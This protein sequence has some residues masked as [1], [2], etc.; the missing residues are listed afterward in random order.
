MR[1]FFWIVVFLLAG[2]WVSGCVTPP[3]STEGFLEVA[4]DDL[5]CP[6]NVCSSEYLLTSNGWLLEKIQNSGDS[7]N[8]V[9]ISVTRVPQESVQ[10][11]W[12]RLPPLFSSSM[13]ANCSSCPVWNSFWLHNGKLTRVNIGK[14]FQDENRSGQLSDIFFELKQLSD[15]ASPSDDLFVQFVFQE[16]G[17]RFVDYHFFPDG[18]FVRS[19]FGFGNGEIL[20]ARVGNDPV[21]VAKVFDSVSDDF[22]SDPAA[23]DCPASLTHGSMIVSKGARESLD[24]FCV[25]SGAKRLFLQLYG[26]WK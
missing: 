25:N 6:A 11:I 21:K 9:S 15:S 8:P 24:F 26:D 18:T 3:A 12:N 23:V 16:N 17:G 20:S 1:S 14:F 10:K 2:I 22:F 7:T 13:D 5:S 4:L 19:E